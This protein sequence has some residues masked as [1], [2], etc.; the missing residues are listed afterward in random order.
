MQTNLAG[1]LLSAPISKEYAINSIRH[2]SPEDV[3]FLVMI[4]YD[5]ATVY[6]KASD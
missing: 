1:T 4:I 5:I 3:T 2:P 6:E